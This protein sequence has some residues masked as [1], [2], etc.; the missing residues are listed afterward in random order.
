MNVKDKMNFTGWDLQGLAIQ[1][2]FKGNLKAELLVESDC[3]GLER[4]PAGI[5][6]RNYEQLP[7]IEQ[8]TL[9]LCKGRILDIGAGAGSHSLILQQ[10][11]F[12]VHALDVSLYAVEVMKKRG[13]QNSYC[14]DIKD[15]QASPFDTILM[16][17]NGIGLVGDLKG[18]ELFLKDIKRLLKPD[19]QLLL[20]S[21]DLNFLKEEPA[22]NVTRVLKKGKNYGKVTYRFEYRGIKGPAFNWLYIDQANLQKYCLQAG[23]DCQVLFEEDFQYLARLTSL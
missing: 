3:A 4:M 5:F 17:M 16:L 18:L 20:D 22:A 2:Y 15:F 14:G 19:G 1:D 13:L 10:Q 11:G 6:F 12:E 9:S 23:W 21:T 8:Y 7:D